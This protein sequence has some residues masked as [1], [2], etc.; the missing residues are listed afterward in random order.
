MWETNTLPLPILSHVP[1]LQQK[2]MCLSWA[3]GMCS[4]GAIATNNDIPSSCIPSFHPFSRHKLGMLAPGNKVGTAQWSEHWQLKQGVKFPVTTSFF[5]VL[6]T[7][8]RIWFMFSWLSSTRTISI[9][10]SIPVEPL[11]LL[12]P[13]LQLR[14]K[15]LKQFSI[16]CF[17]R[18]GQHG[19]RH[20]QQRRE[21]LD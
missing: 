5:F 8:K 18:P 15:L 2:L 4:Y 16:L 12:P 17:T 10:W 13:G 14:E 7:V 9:W 20:Q 19:K 11:L 21:G 3:Y 6:Y 1:D